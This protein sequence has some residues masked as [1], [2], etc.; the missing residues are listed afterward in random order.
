MLLVLHTFDWSGGLVACLVDMWP[1]LQTFGWSGGLVAGLVVLEFSKVPY[2][3]HIKY[4]TM[5]L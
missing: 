1:F 3:D 4:T 5:P 2:V